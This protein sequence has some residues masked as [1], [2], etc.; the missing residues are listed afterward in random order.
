MSTTSTTAPDDRLQDAGLLSQG[1]LLIGR[2]TFT[3]GDEVLALRN[4]YRIGILNGTLG[5]IRKIDLAHDR[6]QVA[7]DAGQLI[8]VPFDY[9]AAGHLTHGYAMTIHKA[10]GATVSRT[11]ILAD[12]TMTREHGYTAMSR[13]VE[14]NDLYLA[15]D[16]P[17]VDERH[18]D[19]HFAEPA[20]SVRRS[21][22]RSAAQHLAIDSAGNQR[23]PRSTP[24]TQGCDRSGCPEM[25]LGL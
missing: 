15:V 18:A 21:L 14:R 9:L 6:L 22:S 12:D 5:A 8:D 25:D 3:V 1:G 23:T 17:R 10:Q 19:E 16:D 2:R 24:A 4:D 13:G 11:L 7:T 20:G